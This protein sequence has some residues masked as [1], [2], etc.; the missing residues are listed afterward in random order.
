[1]DIAYDSKEAFLI[2]KMIFA[3]IYYHS[4]EEKFGTMPRGME[5]TRLSELEKVNYSLK[6]IGKRSRVL[7]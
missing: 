5:N 3:C 4:N 7:L 2:N 1:M 6:E